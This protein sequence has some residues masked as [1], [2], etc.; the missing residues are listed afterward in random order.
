MS[1]VAK[2]RSFRSCQSA[3]RHLDF[4]YHGAVPLGQA[5]LAQLVERLT[6]NEKVESSIL[7]GGS[8]LPFTYGEVALAVLPPRCA[9]KVI[10]YLFRKRIDVVAQFCH[11]GE[12][13]L[14]IKVSIRL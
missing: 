13:I 1:S 9:Q 5:A 3:S 14:N 4:G 2:R 12:R 6:R 7:S 8:V 10:P 11:G